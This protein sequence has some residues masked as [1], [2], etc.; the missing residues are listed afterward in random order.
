M[1][2]HMDLMSFCMKR[3]TTSVAF[4]LESTRQVGLI[5]PPSRH[6]LIRLLLNQTSGLQIN[7][8]IYRF[9]P[10]VIWKS[11]FPQRD[12]ILGVGDFIKFTCLTP[13]VTILF[14]QE[15]RRVWRT[16]KLEPRT[17]LNVSPGA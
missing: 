13:N 12:D 5:N 1:L 3:K 15:I 17:R 8:L 4:G 2:L 14:Y 10:D 11:A 9:F 6:L 16:Y 7:S